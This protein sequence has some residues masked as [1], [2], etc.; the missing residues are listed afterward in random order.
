MYLRYL[1]DGVIII[2]LGQVDKA[3]LAYHILCAEGSIRLG[4]KNIRYPSIEFTWF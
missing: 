4:A 1:F 2:V 3:F